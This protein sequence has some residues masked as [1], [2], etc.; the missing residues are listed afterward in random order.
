MKA[1]KAK[2]SEQRN[3]AAFVKNQ[4]NLKKKQKKID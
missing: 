1:S 3:K 4:K 2:K